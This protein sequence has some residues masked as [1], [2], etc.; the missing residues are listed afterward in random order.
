LAK[1]K[2]TVGEGGKGGGRESRRVRSSGGGG[3]GGLRGKEIRLRIP[4]EKTGVQPW[5]K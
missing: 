1:E 3:G 4:G 2:E 5:F